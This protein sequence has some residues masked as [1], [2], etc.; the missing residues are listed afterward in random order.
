MKTYNIYMYVV[1][2]LSALSF[3]ACA[4]HDLDEEGTGTLDVDVEFIWDKAPKANPT[5]MGFWLYP[6]DNRRPLEYAF[7]GRDGG[8]IRIMPGKYN[9][10]AYNSDSE[11]MIENDMEAITTGTLTTRVTRLLSANAP[12]QYDV[13]ALEVPRAPGTDEQPV[14]TPPDPVWA[15]RAP[16]INLNED[17][18]RVTLHP[19]TLTPLIEVRILNVDNI[20]TLA[21]ASATLTG[22]AGSIHPYTGIIGGPLCTLPFDLEATRAEAV[23]TAHFHT[24]GHCPEPTTHTLTIYT[25]IADG[26]LYLWHFDVTQQIHQAPNPK[27]I[28]ITI[29]QLA[30]PEAQTNSNVT[31]AD[32]GEIYEDIPMYGE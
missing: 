23:M 3:T 19:D 21:W 6:E 5:Q 10:L 26:G 11:V 9:A 18:H 20:E 32:W 12:S 22:M 2:L 24:F 27:H 17:N 4:P 14:M 30:L 7:P 25:E 15:D 29:E 28:I 1:L 16:A 8:R 13:R 31:V